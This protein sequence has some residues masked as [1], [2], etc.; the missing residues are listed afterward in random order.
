M[1]TRFSQARRIVVK[2]GSALL[3]DA[4]TGTLR[5]EWL[6]A[7]ADDIRHVLR[8]QPPSVRPDG[9]GGRIQCATV[10]LPPRISYTPC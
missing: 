3:V 9:F 7:L 6:A 1:S 4:E 2:I 5:D 10:R 8:D